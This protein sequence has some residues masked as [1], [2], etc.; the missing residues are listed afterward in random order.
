[1]NDERTPVLVGGGQI[2]QRDVA[3]EQA[4]EP[5]ALMEAAARRAAEEAGAGRRLFAALDCVAAVSP[6]GWPYRNLPRLLAQRL[7]ARPR[8]EIGTAIGGNLPQ[9]LVNETARAIAQG[10]VRAALLAGAEALHSSRRARRAGVRLAWSA[11][12]E[13]EPT[14]VGD[15]RP[16]SSAAENACGLGLPITMYPI[17]ENALRARRGITIEAQ[18]EALGGLMSRFAA[19]AALNPHAW[20][21]KPHEAHEIAAPGPG[22]RMVAFPYTKRMNAM[23]EV[24]MGA[25]LLMTSAAGARALGIPPERWIHV[26]GG[27]DA[28]EEPWFVSERPDLSRAP[29]LRGAARAA[30]AQAGV[31]IDAIDCFDLYSCFPSAVELACEALGIAADDPRPLTVTGGLPY[32]GGPGNAYGFHAIAALRERLRGTPGA[33]GLVTGVGWYMTRHAVGVYGSAPRPPGAP[34]LEA[35]PGAPPGAAAVPLAL[36]ASGPG[37]IESYTVLHDREGAPVRG[38]VVGRFEDG[39]RFLANTPEDRSVWEELMLRE[40]VGRRGRVTGGGAVQRFLLA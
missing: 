17:F 5:A 38:I 9:R 30:L 28:I 32:A 14:L 15:G 25:A 27:A 35:A 36:D 3:P 26:W 40:G 6:I 21:P 4:L 33:T 20:F 2:V 13:G 19:V 34:P 29:A 18:R 7:G 16:G 37:A 39:R 8:L 23:L 24:D 22:N 31:G 1:M 12:A 10:R 11:G